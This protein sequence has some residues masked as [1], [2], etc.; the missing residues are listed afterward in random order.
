[1]CLFFEWIIG[2]RKLDSYSF[3]WGFFSRLCL[4]LYVVV[5]VTNI[6]SVLEY[7]YIAYRLLLN[8]NF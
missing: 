5:V 2:Q 8:I 6:N 4:P 3:C 7:M 1:M